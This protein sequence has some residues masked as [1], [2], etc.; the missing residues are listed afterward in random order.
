MIDPFSIMWFKK[1][2]KF[3]FDSYWEKLQ[4]SA[5]ARTTQQNQQQSSSLSQQQ[6]TNSGT[7]TP[8]PTS[9]TSLL[10]AAMNNQQQQLQQ[11]QNQRLRGLL[12]ILNDPNY[13][14]TKQKFLA[15]FNFQQPTSVNVHTFIAKLKQWIALIE[16]HLVN[17]MPR[18]HLL[19]ER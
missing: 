1:I 15:D 9:N 3:Y 8:I 13:Q 6:G 17:S 5:A 12:A 11:P 7:S 19:D 10:A 14:L 4:Q 16:T 18:Q 2:H